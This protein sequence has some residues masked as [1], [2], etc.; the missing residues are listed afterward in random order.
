MSTITLKQ[1]TKVMEWSVGIALH[2][3]QGECQ[4]E[5]ESGR[6]AIEKLN[7]SGYEVIQKSTLESIVD[8][9]NKNQE[10]M[11]YLESC[12]ERN[13]ATKADENGL[14]INMKGLTH[15]QATK[16]LALHSELTGKSSQV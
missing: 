7:K 16:L 12:M 15:D 14:T 9:H 8:I 1:I 5:S 11:D 13:I 10:Y 6:R 2:G 4:K 3:H